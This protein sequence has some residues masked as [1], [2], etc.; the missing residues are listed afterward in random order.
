MGYWFWL[1][2]NDEERKGTI[3]DLWNTFSLELT[4]ISLYLSCLHFLDLTVWFKVR[5]N[6]LFLGIIFLFFHLVKFCLVAKKKRIFFCLNVIL[7]SWK[8]DEEKKWTFMKVQK[9]YKTLWMF[10]PLT[11]KLPIQ[12][13]WQTISVRKMKT[14]YK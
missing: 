4:A 11:T 7:L 8:Q 6:T 10:R 2:L 13:L 12:V 9:L 1:R 3:K 5:E 14:S